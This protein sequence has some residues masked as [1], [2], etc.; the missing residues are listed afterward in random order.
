MGNAKQDSP[1]ANAQDK[2]MIERSWVVS[3]LREWPQPIHGVNRVIEAIEAHAP[4]PV[5]APAQ[6]A[7]AT[8]LT[9]AP[10]P[11][12]AELIEA[13][14]KQQSCKNCQGTGEAVYFPGGTRPC[15]VCN[16]PAQSPATAPAGQLPGDEEVANWIGSKLLPFK[17]RVGIWM[18]MEWLRT[19]TPQPAT[20]ADATT[21]PASQPA[22]SDR[23]MPT[24]TL[25]Y[26]VG[27]E[28]LTLS[29]SPEVAELYACINFAGVDL[30]DRVRTLLKTFLPGRRWELVGP[31]HIQTEHG[32]RYQINDYVVFLNK[33][34]AGESYELPR[35]IGTE[36]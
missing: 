3:L 10:G 34:A 7:T 14:K 27:D 13:W 19:R 25:R 12:A 20:N 26:A 4:A 9:I 24:V 28:V 23:G 6:D 8:K 2:A 11:T 18:C 5:T 29:S 21:A 36:T 22:A 31:G 32:A 30:P 33:M 15:H 17:H 1:P 16:P 35:V